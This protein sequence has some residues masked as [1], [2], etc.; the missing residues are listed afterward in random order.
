MPELLTAVG[1]AG[2]LHISVQT[3]HRYR[4]DGQLRVVGTYI[5]PSRH[6]VPLF[7]A[8]DLEQL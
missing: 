1:V 3:V 6:I 5:R 7:N 4:R 8:G 2:R